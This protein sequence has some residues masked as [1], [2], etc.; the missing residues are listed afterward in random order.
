MTNKTHTF[1]QWVESVKYMLIT[2]LELPHDA[3]IDTTKQ[4]WGDYYDD[5]LTPLEAIN[6][7]LSHTTP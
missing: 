5:G 1:E 2:S 3:E 6:E 7:D 4:T